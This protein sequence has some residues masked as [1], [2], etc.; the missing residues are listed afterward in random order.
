[1]KRIDI[2]ILMALLVPISGV[3]YSQQ[4]LTML[5]LPKAG[6]A[7]TS[8][9]YLSRGMNAIFLSDVI[10]E[11]EKN[12]PCI[13]VTDPQA[14][15]YCMA[16]LRLQGTAEFGSRDV[17]P[18]MARIANSMAKPDLAV[19]YCMY[20]NSDES[21]TA[22]VTCVNSEGE[23]IAEFSESFQASQTV[24]EGKSISP[25]SRLVEELKKHEICPYTGSVN[26]ETE[27]EREE[28]SYTSTPCDAGSVVTDVE[29]NSNSMLKWDLMKEGLVRAS[30]NVSYDQ[31]EKIKIVIKNPCYICQDGTKGFA[32]TTETNE[33]EAN[34]KGLSNESVTDGAQ[35]ADARIR[36]TFLDNGTYLL[37]VKATSDKGPM[38]K[39]TEKKVDGPCLTDNENEPPDTKTKS[40]DVPFTAVF[41][42]YQGT[43]TDKVLS[44]SEEKD[45]STGKEK[46]TLKIDF[47]L[48][49][50]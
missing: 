16:E 22:S 44:Q 37:T 40:I 30:G 9:L 10:N 36:L 39:T 47:T 48:T 42:P 45:L 15:S 38:K 29:I 26:I 18:I 21:V 46:V 31:K 33:T 19:R 43:P 5:L 4:H 23:I 28:S 3:A 12:F 6:A 24:Q 32:T 35:T 17:G 2:I 13:G 14:A 7:D 8:L 1:M 50:Q 27:S 11:M 20:V 41:G 49:R 25:V 34:V